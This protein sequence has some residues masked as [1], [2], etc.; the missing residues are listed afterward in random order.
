MIMLD[1]GVALIKQIFFPGYFNQLL[2]T[3]PEL[4]DLP[5]IFTYNIIKDIIN[6]NIKNLV[7]IAKKS[8]Y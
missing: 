4:I 8:V 3:D 7:F 1:I 6:L 5:K 2:K